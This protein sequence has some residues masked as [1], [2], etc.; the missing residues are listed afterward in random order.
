MFDAA[1]NRRQRYLA[2]PLLAPWFKD[3]ALP[4]VIGFGLPAD[5]APVHLA[6]IALNPSAREVTEGFVPP[7]D[8]ASAHWGPQTTYFTRPYRSWFDKAERIVRAASGGKVSYGGVYGTGQPCVH[9]DVSPLPTVG[10]FDTVFDVSERSREERDA[11]IALLGQDSRELPRPLLRLL[12]KQHHLS[13]ALIL[14]YCPPDGGSR[15]MKRFWRRGAEFTV[16]ASGIE[17]GTQWAVGEWALGTSSP[18][19]V[20]F[21]S[22]GPSSQAVIGDLEKAASCLSRG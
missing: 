7:S 10:N 3:T 2:D 9:L 4:P 19:P 18:L 12:V 8:D 11:A 6:T 13:Q 14:G 17:A 1:L 21:L 20:A 22:K 5:D 15:T 16:R